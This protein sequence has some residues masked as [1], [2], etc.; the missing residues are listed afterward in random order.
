MNGK[1]GL[2]RLYPMVQINKGTWEIDEFDIASMF[3]LEGTEKAMLIDTG[4][5][6]GDLRGAVELITEK[7]LVVVHSHGHIDHTGNARQ[8]EEIWLHPADRHM[9]IPDA[10]ERRR[11]DAEHI[12]QRQ[13]GS[14]GAPYNLFN[15]YPYDIDVD[16]RDPGD[17]P[18]PVIH[19]LYDGQ[20]F[21]LGGRIVTVY[22]CPGHTAGEVVFLDE[23]N[24]MLFAGDAVNFNL[25]LGAVPTETTLAAMKRIRDMGDRY[26]GIWNGHHDFRALGAPLDDDCLETIIALLEDAVKGNVSYCECPSFWGQPLPLRRRG[27]EMKEEGPWAQGKPTYLRR[28]RNFLQLNF[29]GPGGK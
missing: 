16:L 28:G 21:D 11:F 6:V 26:D 1:S 18:M 2:T 9:P 12:A 3:L 13:K 29:R 4:M 5:G 23:T 20:Q 27:S 10:V 25:L 8:F 7:P 24:R 15:L 22:E 14:I 17:A 19:D